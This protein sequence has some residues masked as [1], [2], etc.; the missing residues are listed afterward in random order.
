MQFRV[1]KQV[2][3]LCWC[4][5][6]DLSQFSY[7]AQVYETCIEHKKLVEIEEWIS[8]CM[9]FIEFISKSYEI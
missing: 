6:L 1:R 9:L 5:S 4:E 8:I 2:I 7:G 3:K